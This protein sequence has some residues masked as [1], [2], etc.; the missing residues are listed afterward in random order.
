MQVFREVARSVHRATKGRQRPWKAE[1]ILEDFY[2]RGPA[3]G[4]KSDQEPSGQVA[5]QPP[6]TGQRAR[7]G[8]GG[9]FIADLR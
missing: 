6:S 8:G 4:S 3:S 7:E 9:C 2:F 5:I 1:D